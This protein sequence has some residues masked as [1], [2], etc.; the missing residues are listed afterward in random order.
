MI[1]FEGTM[2]PGDRRL[3]G[4]LLDYVE[5]KCEDHLRGFAIECEQT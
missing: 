1:C 2:I 5:G 3:L 4:P